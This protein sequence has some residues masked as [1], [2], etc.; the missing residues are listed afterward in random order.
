MILYSIYNNFT[1]FC[2]NF[3][4]VTEKILKNQLPLIMALNEIKKI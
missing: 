1:V 2:K 3:N 4:L